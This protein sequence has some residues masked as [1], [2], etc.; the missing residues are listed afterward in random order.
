MVD[1]IN[2]L[3]E[4]EFEL[5]DML[6]KESPNPSRGCDNPVERE[7]LIDGIENDANSAASQ[8]DLSVFGAYAVSSSRPR[9]NELS[10]SEKSEPSEGMGSSDRGRNLE[11]VDFIKRLEE[12]QKV[13]EKLVDKCRRLGLVLSRTTGLEKNFASKSREGK[14]VTTTRELTQ[15]SK[16]LTSFVHLQGRLANQLLGFST[17]ID[18]LKELMSQVN[19]IQRS[20]PDISLS[21]I[22]NEEPLGRPY[23]F[24]LRGSSYGIS[25]LSPSTDEAAEEENVVK[26]PRSYLSLGLHDSSSE[27]SAGD[28]PQYLR[29]LREP[30]NRDHGE[31]ESAFVPIQNTTHL[32]PTRDKSKGTANLTGSQPDINND[33]KVPRATAN[34]SL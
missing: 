10:K 15:R 32:G 4:C 23:R 6:A 2:G 20:A 8:E 30:F 13:N 29:T 26:K 5:M 9:P 21:K 18:E 22:E 34:P 25:A 33:V 28:Y 1:I 16:T 12:I 14:D 27:T 19:P 11:G 24:G 31:R 3:H 7:K 17:E